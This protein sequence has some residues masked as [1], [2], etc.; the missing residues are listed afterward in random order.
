M[1]EAKGAAEGLTVVVVHRWSGKSSV[2]WYPWL[3]TELG[4]LGVRVIVPNMPNTD[5]PTVESWTGAL[6]KTLVE[7]KIA[8]NK[9]VLVGH[10]VGAQTV[11]RHLAQVG[12]MK[13]RSAEDRFRGALLVAVWF[14][15][16]KAWDS[17]KPWVEAPIDF[18]SVKN[19]CSKLAAVISDNDQYT[20]DFETTR[21]IFTTNLGT[22]EL[23]KGLKH[24]NESEY[25]EILASIKAVLGLKS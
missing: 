21:K 4:K 24:F 20:S 16:D 8:P 22:V 6:A 10:S 18:L 17:A 7:H 19:A 11:M 1:S 5:V 9:T 12:S 13:L 14:T 2:D 3:T 25:P 15:I 23:F